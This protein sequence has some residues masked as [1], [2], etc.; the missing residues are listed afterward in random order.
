MGEFKK[1]AYPGTCSV[2][3]KQTDVVVCASSFGATSYAY[4]ED[5]LSNHLEPYDAMVDY[6][7]C[8]GLFPDDI[9]PQYQNLC[10]HILK[11]LG[12]SEEQFIED[13]R[14][15]NED[16]DEFAQELYMCDDFDFSVGDYIK[17]NCPEC[18]A[19]LEVMADYLIEER[20][21]DFDS[22]RYERRN[23]I[24]HCYKCHCDWENEWWTEFGDVGESPLERKFWG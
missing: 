8:A 11:G 12:I 10:R 1:Y 2:C 22:F 21:A 7:G 19:Q 15:T 3:G 18:G 20:P 23:L 24:R 16:L 4:C 13:V 6:I 14:K 5:C 17:F 9:N